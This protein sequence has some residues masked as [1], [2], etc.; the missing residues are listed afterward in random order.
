MSIRESNIRVAVYVKKFSEKE[1]MLFPERNQEE[2]CTKII[3]ANADWNLVG[4]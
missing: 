3:G 2:I 4:I 1:T